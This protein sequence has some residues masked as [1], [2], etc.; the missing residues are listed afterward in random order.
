MAHISVITGD[1]IDSTSVADPAAFRARLV[2]LLETL[3][4]RFS[5]WTSIYRGDGFQVGLP[6][7][8]NAFRIALVLRSGLIAASPGDG[9]RWDARVAI[10]FGTGSLS[11]RNQG[12][13][14]HVNSGRSLDTMGKAHLRV[15]AEDETARLALDTA[16]GFV[17]EMVNGMSPAEAEA[18][19]YHLLYGESHQRIAER[20]G[21]QRATVTQTLNRARYKLLETYAD[22]M[23]RL[24]RIN[25]VT[26]S[27]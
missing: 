22:N 19:Y 9:E 23:D 4:D 15:H 13:G 26:G 1:L 11:D 27:P 21:K 14:A 17:D 10:A 8:V 18:V 25:R 20:L 16:T 24:V 6:D 2:E 7:P 3:Q 12:S 5:A